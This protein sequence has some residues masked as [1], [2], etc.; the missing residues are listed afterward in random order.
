[1]PNSAVL[2]QSELH[3][4]AP[5]GQI[6]DPTALD[7]KI[8]GTGLASISTKPWAYW[9][10]ATDPYDVSGNA[11]H[12]YNGRVPLYSQPA[13]TSKCGLSTHFANADSFFPTTQP[14]LGS[15]SGTYTYMGMLYFVEIP[16]TGSAVGSRYL[17]S[18][19]MSQAVESTA[20]FDFKLG[21]QDV[22]DGGTLIIQSGLS[23]VSGV[24]GRA[25]LNKPMVIAVVG[26]SLPSL[27]WTIDVWLNGVKVISGYPRY[28]SSG[29]TAGWWTMGRVGNTERLAAFR[30]SNWAAWEGQLQDAQIMGLTE[31]YMDKAAYSAAWKP[32]GR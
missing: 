23:V 3:S 29:G 27:V 30:A 22:G 32:V 13:I 15:S 26:T 11:H 8:M 14:K 12:G 19:F 21:F 1:M 4:Y 28:A 20:Q 10:M 5:Y 16:A 6:A 7:A 18:T 25:Q 31:A 17:G 24:I 9:P 2:L